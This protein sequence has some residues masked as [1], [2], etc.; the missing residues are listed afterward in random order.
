M[1]K[2]DFVG[3]VGIGHIGLPL[4]VALSNVGY[5]VIGLDID[6]KKI[7]HLKT[8]NEPYFYEPG[9]SETLKRC[10]SRIEFTT[11]YK[12]LVEKCETIIFTVG[13]E[14]NH[15]GE[16]NFNSLDS[17]LDNI[18]KYLTRGQLI[19]LKS[20]VL[21][22]TTEIRARERLEKESNL[23]CGKDFHLVYCPER[24]IEGLALHELYHLPKII[25]GINQ[26]STK[27]ASKIIG[28]LGGKIVEV[29]SPRVAEMCKL[30]DNLYRAINVAFVNEVGRTCEKIGIDANEVAR[31]VNESYER[32]N[33]FKPGLGAGG[34]CLPKDSKM[35]LYVATKY[36]SDAPLTRVSIQSNERQNIDIAEKVY[37]FIQKYEIIKPIISFLGIAFK[38]FP[39]TDDI[40]G[41][42][43]LTIYNHLRLKLPNARFSFYDPVIEKGPPEFNYNLCSDMYSCVEG[44]NV[45]LFLSNH[46]RLMKIEP[47]KII[48]RAGR[49]L[50]IVDAWRN[51]FLSKSLKI[52]EDVQIYVV[53][54]GLYCDF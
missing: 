15:L 43:Q 24:T 12:Y 32:T 14:V 51:L 35:F 1:S 28:R 39:E 16:P 25:G 13:T 19:V 26:E 37:M 11:D 2:E 31:A 23:K 48:D 38:G 44:S 41:A 42:P 10:R 34:P 54:S 45:V 3:V 7:D 22:G 9:V 20:T 40:R 6:K 53:G 36:G 47:L 50:L 21:P 46:P 29:S 49:P 52:S 18:G 8:I 4:T 17:A 30:V 5:N 27:R 33:I